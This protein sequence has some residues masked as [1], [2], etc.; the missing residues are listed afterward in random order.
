M[1]ALVVEH[2]YDVD[3]PPNRSAQAPTHEYTGG[4]VPHDAPELTA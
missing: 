2:P 1:L 3:T 4:F